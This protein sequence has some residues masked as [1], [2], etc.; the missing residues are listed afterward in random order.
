VRRAARDGYALAESEDDK[1][2]GVCD[3]LFANQVPRR[4][5]VIVKIAGKNVQGSCLESTDV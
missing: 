2:R 5:T 1:T 4:A 3:V